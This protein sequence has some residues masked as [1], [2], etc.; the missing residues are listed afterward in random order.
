MH[1]VPANE[2]Y[3]CIERAIGVYE[4]DRTAS[5]IRTVNPFFW[6]NK[7]IMT[8][9]SIPFRVLGNIGF[10]KGK[11]EASLSGRI[12]KGIL[13]IATLAASGLYILDTLGILDRT[14]ALINKVLNL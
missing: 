5:I 12:F 9:V 2:V 3:D 1:R 11:A 6:I 8:I 10:N 14:L 4:H 7:I 13:Y